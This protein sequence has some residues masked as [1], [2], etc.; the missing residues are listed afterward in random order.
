MINISYFLNIIQRHA[1]VQSTTKKIIFPL[2]EFP[3]GDKLKHQQR[4]VDRSTYSYYWDLKREEMRLLST[5]GLSN[6]TSFEFH[7]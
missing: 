6:L 4:H 3:G 5:G 7:V 2:K 1:T